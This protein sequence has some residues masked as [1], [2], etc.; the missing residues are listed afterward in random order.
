MNAITRPS[1]QTRL[2]IRRYH[3]ALTLAALLLAFGLGLHRL[4]AESLWY[5]ETVSALLAAKPIPAM[6]AHTAGDIH[7]PGYYLLLH[8]WLQVAG[9][10]S[11]TGLPPTGLEFI[12]AWPSLWFGLLTVALLYPIGRRLLDHNQRPSAALLGMGLAAIHPFQ[13]WY[14]QEV[15]MYT[16]GSSL[17]L[18]CLWALLQALAIGAPAGTRPAQHRW[19]AV[20]AGAAAL[21][22]YTLYYFAF[23]LA[24]LNLIAMM[25]LV[26]RGRPLRRD[27]GRWLAAQAA[28]LLLWLPW[29]PIFVRQALEPPV[30]P[31]R[32]PWQGAADVAAS[33]AE[34][35]G[36][37]VVGQSPPAGR[38][39]PWALAA[40]LLLLAYFGYTK[41]SWGRP[42]RVAENPPAWI[43]PAYVLV[44]PTLILLISLTVTPLYHV[45]YLFTYAPPFALMAAAAILA[46]GRRS[47]LLE[48]T[49]AALLV[50]ASGWSL[51][52]FWQNPRYH[53][54]DHRQA[55]A[56]LAQAWRPGDVILVNA[57]W[58]Y[59]ALTTYW[60][61]QW[62]D[63]AHSLPP[64]LGPLQRLTDYAKG[65]PPRP[66]RRQTVPLVR[67]GS[68]DGSPQ[69]GWGSPTSDFFAMDAQET[70]AALEQLASH[71]RRI[72]HYRI[73]DTVSDPN[74]LIRTWLADHGRLLLDQAYPGRDYLRLQLFETEGTAA[75]TDPAIADGVTFGDPL[76]LIQH[77]QPQEQ[78]A[79]S[80][81]YV[82]LDWARTTEPPGDLAMS[83]RLYDAQDELWA[84]QDQGPL[85]PVAEWPATGQI[86][87]L[88]LPI[89]LA[90]RPGTYRLE[91]VV[92]RRENGEPLAVPEGERSRFGQRWLL[93]QVTVTPPPEA[94]PLPAAW[95]RLARF[96]YIDLLQASVQTPTPAPGAA[97]TLDLIWRPNPS[98]YQDTYAAVLSLQDG[99]GRL[100][101]QWRE[102]LGGDSYPSGAWP[103]GVP[104][105]DRL[106]LPLAPDLPPGRYRLVVGLVRTSDGLAIPARRP[107]RP[108]PVDG[109]EIGEIAIPR[110]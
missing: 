98:P 2:D 43:L 14:S 9:G 79:G 4:G 12:L 63:P 69:L 44:P 25:W 60:P 20:Y 109:V 62:T 76:R 89:P 70:E 37:L 104:V 92:Y 26:G 71:Y 41:K 84:Q 10:A 93:G 35:L 72:W 61:A 16:L 32:P 31:W 86:Q 88:G 74:G 42:G 82:A 58:A 99:Q 5:D 3:R 67:T 22:L 91:L 50:V 6:L 34:A 73:Y 56:D 45:R 19:L 17:G 105:W 90:L 81:L 13:I 33:L 96:D 38:Y 21:G 27:L 66:E 103:A 8:L 77:W 78:A 97:V 59:T 87:V 94:L 64:P 101:Q 36:A 107:W 15:R 28:A 29:L 48:T 52:Q 39:G 23:A 80:W 102:P 106:H 68:V 57:G 40:I 24:A 51:H 110:P 49:V 75:P 47:Q 7:P 11:P 100:R 46:L 55:V 83:L 53:S 85:P 65:V 30:P 18:V 54:D 1:P 95:P 108:W